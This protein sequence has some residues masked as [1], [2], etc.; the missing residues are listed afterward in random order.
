M[1]RIALN[2]LPSLIQF[3][4]SVALSL[5]QT[6]DVFVRY[7]FLFKYS[8]IVIG[9]RLF[10]FVLSDILLVI[11]I[12]QLPLSLVRDALNLCISSGFQPGV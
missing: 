4:C 1:E 2:S 3:S 9:E 10:E 12:C 7:Y 6:S 5:Q 8:C 11:G